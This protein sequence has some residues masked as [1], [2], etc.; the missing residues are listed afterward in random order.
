[1]AVVSRMAVVGF[2]ALVAGS[3]AVDPVVAEN[4]W[5]NRPAKGKPNNHRWEYNFLCI[6]PQYQ[7]GERFGT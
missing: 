2:A 4:H 3:T 1:M 7:T 5:I 6:A